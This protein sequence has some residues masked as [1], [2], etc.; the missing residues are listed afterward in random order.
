MY[1]CETTQ[2]P[3]AILGS[4]CA[5]WKVFDGESENVTKQFGRERLHGHHGSS[6]EAWRAF[7]CGRQEDV[8]NPRSRERD[9]S[10]ASRHGGR[11]TYDLW[12]CLKTVLQGSED[13]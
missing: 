3:G 4:E 1:E 12:D 11:G 10:R 5:T 13:V 7:Y 9:Q 2:R 8:V 6:G